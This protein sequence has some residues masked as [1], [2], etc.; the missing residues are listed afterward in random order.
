MDRQPR[1]W[2]SS[3][4][5]TSSDFESVYMPPMSL[6]ALRRKMTLVPTQNAALNRLRPGWMNL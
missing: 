2:S 3:D 5:H 1:S 4:V 6:I